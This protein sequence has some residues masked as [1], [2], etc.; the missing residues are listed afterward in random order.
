MQAF[1]F[2][3]CS[4]LPHYPGHGTEC[5]LVIFGKSLVVT[6]E[7]HIDLIENIVG[8]CWRGVS[9]FTVQQ[10][11]VG[12][13]EIVRNFYQPVGREDTLSQLANIAVC[14]T[15]IPLQLG[16]GNF[17]LLAKC[18]DSIYRVRNIPPARLRGKSKAALD[19]IENNLYNEP[20]I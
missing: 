17:P 11:Q 9:S 10:I 1:L 18:F 4:S 7:R 20:M 12:Y 15:Q 2:L 8:I 13:R 16:N 19:K 3:V 5:L 6:V 14:K